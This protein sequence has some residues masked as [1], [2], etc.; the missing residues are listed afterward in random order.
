M[1][2]AQ[3]QSPIRT[4]PPWVEQFARTTPLRIALLILVIGELLVL[5]LMPYERDHA[6]LMLLRYYRR[7]Q[8]AWLMRSDPVTGHRLTA[9]DIGLRPPAGAMGVIA[10]S[11]CEGCSLR[12]VREF[13]QRLN[14]QHVTRLCIVSPQKPSPEGAQLMREQCQKLGV[15]AELV[16]DRRGVVRRRLNVFF[17][18]RGYIIGPAGR[19]AWVQHPHQ[20]LAPEA[21][22]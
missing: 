7:A 1:E 5:T 18:P 13:A 8:I 9:A 19:L 20:P 10:V 21:A 17:T 11:D 16:W 15:R 22:G 2:G 4:A 6:G 14:D 12:G 3:Q